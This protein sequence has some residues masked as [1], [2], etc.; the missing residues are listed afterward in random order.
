MKRFALIA[1]AGGAVAL[2]GPATALAA[3]PTVTTGGATNVAQ[4]TATLNGSV[5]PRGNPTFSYFQVGTTKAYG[6]QTPEVDRGAGSTPVKTPVDLTG[7]A[8]FETYHYRIVAQYGERVV[9]GEDKTF[10]TERQPLGLT[11]VSNPL[12]IRPN[13][14][15]TISGTISGTGNGG[16]E[17]ILQA[18]PFPF[19][20]FTDAGNPQIVDE[21]GN[22]AFPL[23]TVPFN[24]VYRVR[25]PS[26]PNLASP[27]VPV[28]VKPSLSVKAPRTVRRGKKARFTG[29]LTPSNPGAQITI[30]RN[31]KGQWITVK[32]TKLGRSSKF[33][34]GI[35]PFRDGNFRVVV[36][37]DAKYVPD[38]SS[39][40]RIDVKKNRR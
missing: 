7:L 6:G 35:R 19:S 37:P 2:A 20:G 4:T 34:A 29:G 39:T 32:R 8:P 5:N 33:S 38:T 27:E 13:G 24:T 25:V 12:Q 40:K 31:F 26:K 36:T 16:R 28:N 15:T 11:L 9:L 22:F 10:R 21:A 23:L 17:V 18:N 30:Q 3:P 1:L 14:S